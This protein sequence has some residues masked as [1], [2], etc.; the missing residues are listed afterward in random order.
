MQG[1]KISNVSDPV[2][3][4]DVVTMSFA[5]AHYLKQGS[6]LDLKITTDN[7]LS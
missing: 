6:E 4:Q 3:A 2:S 7:E 5:D 1:H